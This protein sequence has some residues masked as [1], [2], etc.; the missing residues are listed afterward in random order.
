MTAAIISL[1]IILSLFTYAL[2]KASNRDRD[3]M[4]QEEVLSRK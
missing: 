4:E 2:F 3:D 1:V